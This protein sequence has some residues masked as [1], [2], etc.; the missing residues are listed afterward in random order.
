MPEGKESSH[1]ALKGLFRERRSRRVG[2]GLVS[3]LLS[4]VALIAT[5]HN[6]WPAVVLG[7]LIGV[8]Y[9]LTTGS[10]PFAY[11]ESVFTAASLVIPVWATFSLIVF[12]I[13][14][15]A[16]PQWAAEDI[17]RLFPQFVGWLLY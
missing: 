1:A 15:G 16:G 12:P 17:R 8:L 9:A 2:I 5:L 13:L 11:A 6:V 7:A 10:A 4:S 14:A 3:G